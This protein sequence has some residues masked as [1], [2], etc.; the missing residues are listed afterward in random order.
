MKWVYPDIPGDDVLEFSEQFHLSYL[1]TSILLNRNIRSKKDLDL[2]FNKNVYSLYDPFLIRDMKTAVDVLISACQEKKKILIYGDYDVDGVTST[3]ILYLFLK[4][5]NESIYYY[6][7]EREKDGYGVSPEGIDHAVELD[8]D[9]IIT[10]DCGITA[11][12]QVAR[13]KQNGI[14]VII[15]DHHEQ[16]DTLPDA[17][18]VLNPKRKDDTYPFRDLCGAGVVYKLV[19][20]ICMTLFGSSEKAETYLDLVAIGTAADIVPL[21][22]EN[23]CLV[24]EGLARIRRRECR[25]GILELFN[26]CQID[27]AGISVVNIVF[28]L[29]PRLNAV[30][31]MGSAS[32]AI[33]LLTTEDRQTAREY[34]QILHQENEERQKVERKVTEEAIL[35]VKEIYGDD[36]PKAV[37]LAGDWHPGV[38]GIVSSKV[39]DKIHRPVFLIALK[40]G[41]GKGSG[42]SITS[43]DLYDALSNS[44]EHLSGYGGH[45]MA[46]GLTIDEENISAFEEQFLQY[47]NSH[48]TEDMLEPSIYVEADIDVKDINDHLMDFLH[49]ME[50]FGPANMRPK[51]S[52]SNVTTSNV[53]ILKDK[54]LKFTVKQNGQSLN[55]IG[56]NMLEKFELIMDPSQRIDMVF[57]PTINEWNGVRRIQLVVKDIKSSLT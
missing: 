47:A 29:A 5:L 25:V 32:R 38:I 46:A 41:F 3:S 36:L 34:S 20:A 14:D 23:R 30:G 50:P 15:S 26:I 42:R 40:D 2:Y 18:A 24:R 13:A 54:H 43:F 39:K 51:F 35:Q 33:T 48:I 31:R 44:S 7:P 56:W 45:Q 37:V 57:V 53:T 55:C 12:E 10:C 4:N 21:V 22:D 1:Y 8:I 19:E 11:H 17:L 16:G 49:D 9:L 52:V 6:I 27:T 28:G